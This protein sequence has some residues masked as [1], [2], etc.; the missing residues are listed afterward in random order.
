MENS[1]IVKN[2]NEQHLETPANNE[3]LDEAQ[4]NSVSNKNSSSSP[5]PLVATSNEVNAT[6]ND[7]DDDDDY[8]Y[9]KRLKI[10]EDVDVDEKNNAQVLSSG[11]NE[12]V[13]LTATSDEEGTIITQEII[14]ID[15]KESNERVEVSKTPSPLP[16]L[17]YTVADET[18]NDDNAPVNSN[19]SPPTGPDTDQSC[20]KVPPLKIICSKGDFSLVTDEN[21]KSNDSDITSASNST[22]VPGN[23]SPSTSNEEKKLSEN[24]NKKESIKTTINL[25]KTTTNN[26][27]ND[28]SESGLSSELPVGTLT[29]SIS[30]N[31]IESKQTQ[32]IN[33]RPI[34]EAAMNFSV[35]STSRSTLIT[36]P[37][38][39]QMVK[40]T[41]NRSN[42]GPITSS[43]TTPN[44][45][46][47][48]K[49]RSHTRQQLGSGA[50]SPSNTTSN[51]SADY[52]EV[53]QE[54]SEDYN[55][56]KETTAS[57]TSVDLQLEDTLNCLT[58]N[59]RRRKVR[60]QQLGDTS[61]SSDVF[62]STIS[63][64]SQPIIPTTV[65]A[66][67]GKNILKFFF[68]S[69]TNLL[70]CNKGANVTPGGTIQLQRTF[71]NT[72][73]CFKQFI[74]IRKEI[75]KRRAVLK[76]STTEPKLPK[77][78]EEFC[79]FKKNY[80]IKDNKEALYSIPFVSIN[81]YS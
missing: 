31:Q 16:P 28:N 23:V 5:S 20:L 73:N 39:D 58:P 9:S 61:I 52:I 53:N 46:I 75:I 4:P 3:E 13:T 40:P 51:S 37:I 26:N 63:N 69:R 18:A 72:N 62:G 17:N 79:L 11:S 1:E 2:D 10:V 48:R 7:D 50:L 54:E 24:D 42:D 57:D 67:I 49:L 71:L 30:K 77:N 56:K 65:V 27:S 34:R 41:M 55:N 68:H 14:K 60:Q 70:L 21:Q 22:T 59:S 32:I 47:R 74:E 43:P 44:N 36:S 66:P 29:R 8:M 81:Q 80:L 38:S 6:D 35:R 15:E 78:F 64:T 19:V 76:K 45:L 33:R 25:R 12:T